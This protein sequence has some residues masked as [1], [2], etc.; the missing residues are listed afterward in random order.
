MPRP[1][2]STPKGR[3]AIQEAIATHHQRCSELDCAH[4]MKCHG[5][6]NRVR[7]VLDGEEWCDKCQT[8]QR[9]VTHGW[10][11]Y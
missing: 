2:R 1:D 5:C 6:G 7:I 8:Y 3:K 4:S 9:P 10:S 11:S